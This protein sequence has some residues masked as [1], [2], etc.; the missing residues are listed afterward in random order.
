MLAYMFG[1][2][3][4][5]SPTSL[6]GEIGLGDERAELLRFVAHRQER[7]MNARD[8][9]TQILDASAE[10]PVLEARLGPGRAASRT[11]AR[12]RNRPCTR[13]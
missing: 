2:G 10:E 1:S 12:R 9:F 7:T 6:Y 8:S 3:G 5:N 11:S 4:E 13:R